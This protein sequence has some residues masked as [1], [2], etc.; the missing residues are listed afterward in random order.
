FNV[1]VGAGTDGLLAMWFLKWLP[2]AISHGHNPLVTDYVDSQVGVN[3]MWNGSMPLVDL[4]FVPVTST[5]GPVFSY[6]LVATLA[7]AL[8]AWSAFLLVVSYVEKST[9][10]GVGA[11][12]YGFE[13]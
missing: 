8:S 6:N 5:L 10:A 11:L 3:L 4:V 7:V 12:F 9:A 13:Q 1:Q 2:F